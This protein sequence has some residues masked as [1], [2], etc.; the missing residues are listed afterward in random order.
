[1]AAAPTKKNI[2]CRAVC[3]AFE[4]KVTV[5]PQLQEMTLLEAVINPFLGEFNERRKYED[6]V[7]ASQ[8]RRIEVNNKAFAPDVSAAVA[9]ATP[10]PHVHAD[11]RP[12][13]Q[14]FPPWSK[15][16][17]GPKSISELTRPAPP[18]VPPP[19]STAPIRV[20]ND[21]GAANPAEEPA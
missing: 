6:P 16:P 14:L 20:P 1:M 7:L 18:P 13:V 15:A 11:D 10:K 3:D 9:L 2:R 12:K 17:M 8:L 5:T 4:L 19:K 21:W